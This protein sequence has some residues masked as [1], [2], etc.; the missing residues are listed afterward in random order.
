MRTYARAFSS[1]R[2]AVTIARSS[3]P[4]D[5]MPARKLQLQRKGPG[6]GP[7]SALENLTG[8]EYIM[9]YNYKFIHMFIERGLYKDNGRKHGNYYSII[10]CVC[11]CVYIYIYI[12]IGD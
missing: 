7:Q 1:V 9:G 5:P 8:D 3:R 11:V 6:E 10:G 2:D 4:D 12:S